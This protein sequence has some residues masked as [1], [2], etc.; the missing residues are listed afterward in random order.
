[1]DPPLFFP[2][3]GV[4]TGN[5]SFSNEFEISLLSLLVPICIS[6]LSYASAS[7]NTLVWI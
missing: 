3:S 7:G 4:P 1:M 6:D 5:S 2:D